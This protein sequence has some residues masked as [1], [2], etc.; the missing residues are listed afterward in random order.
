MDLMKLHIQQYLSTHSL[1][2]LEAAFGI[3]AKRHA[4]FPNL[5]MLK[6]SQ[7]NS[8]MAEPV[9]QQCR[10]IILDQTNDW[11]VVSYPFDKFFNYGEPNAAAIDWPR[12]KV[13]EKL[14]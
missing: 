5:V 14:D 12:A 4:Q 8:P 11:A 3:K 6:Y 9:V 7:I 13:Y 1:T 10:G 2:E